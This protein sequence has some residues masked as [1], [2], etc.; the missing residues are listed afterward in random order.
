MSGLVINFRSITCHTLLIVIVEDGERKL[1][2]NA[3][4]AVKVW[5]RGV[6]VFN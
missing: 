5:M 6:A 2:K 1:T 3:G 4:N